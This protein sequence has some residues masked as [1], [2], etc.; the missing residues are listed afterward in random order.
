MIKRTFNIKSRICRTLEALGPVESSTRRSNPCSS[1]EVRPPAK[2][3]KYLLR[4]LFIIFRDYRAPRGIIRQISSQSSQTR[5]RSNGG[6]EE[7]FITRGILCGYEWRSRGVCRGKSEC[8][9]MTFGAPPA[10]HTR[11]SSVCHDTADL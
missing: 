9:R 2:Q 10:S 4:E 3:K 7:E 1:P 6:G 5:G 8:S 11:L